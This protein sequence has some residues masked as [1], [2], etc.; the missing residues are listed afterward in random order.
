MILPQV[1]KK[2]YSIIMIPKQLFF[3]KPFFFLPLSIIPT[4]TAS[5]EQT[6]QLIFHDMHLTNKN[7][8][9]FHVSWL[10]ETSDHGRN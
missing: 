4:E 3:H 8:H 10:D 6:I 2:Q 1:D 7:K 9:G 5:T